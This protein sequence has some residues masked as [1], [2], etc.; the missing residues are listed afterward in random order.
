MTNKDLDRILPFVVGFGLT[1]TG[2]ALLAWKPGLLDLPDAKP[3][4]ENPNQTAVQNVAQSARDKISKA[5][6]D[7]AATSISHSLLITG[8]AMIIVR[9][10]DELAARKR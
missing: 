3:I 2:A 6:P 1:I 4:D 9:V 7:N 8:A 10:L 5:M